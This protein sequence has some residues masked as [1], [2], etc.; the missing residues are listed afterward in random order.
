MQRALSYALSP[1][2]GVPLRF[3][4]LAPCFGVLAG[5]L[6]MAAG[7]ELFSSR[8]S[9]A[10]LAATHLLTI[11]YLALAM[12]GSML[13]LIPVV[14]GHTVPFA[15]A[16]GALGWPGLGLGAL[17]L[18]AAFLGAG[19]PLFITAAVLLP[20]AFGVVLAAVVPPLLKASPA[21]ALPMVRGM[22][23]AIPALALTVGLGVALAAWLSGGPALPVLVLTNLHAGWGLVGW[24]AM[25]VVCVG[26]PVIPM[27]EATGNYPAQVVRLLPPAMA[28]ALLGWTAVVWLADGAAAIAAVVLATV[29]ASFAG[30]TLAMLWR[31]KRRPA[32][33]T[34]M[35]WYL[36]LGSLLACLPAVIADADPLL[37][38]ILGICGFAIAAVNGMLYKI[39]PFLLWYHLQ[40]DPRARKEAVPSIRTVVPDQHAQRQFKLYCAA[41]AAMLGAVAWP[42]WCGALA[43]GL[44]AAASLHLAVDLG[45]AAWL[46]R[47]IR[48]GF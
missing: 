1:A 48:Q 18:A 19:P 20:L 27:F 21:A 15:R 4:L 34:I 31:R 29:V 16:A 32:E 11:G 28:L 35:Y 17:A 40:M 13:Q 38:G 47:R 44:F 24:V 8:W 3:L 36:S 46:C 30:L 22:R 39:V 23:F 14:T 37:L 33:A 26:F 12:A 41:L 10:A 43:G 7:A 6:A 9:P 2:P 25:L 42:Q 5:L 45:R